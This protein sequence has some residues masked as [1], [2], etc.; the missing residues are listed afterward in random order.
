MH[1]WLKEIENMELDT[2][3]SK[4]KTNVITQ[5]KNKT[6]NKNFSYIE[7]LSAFE[8][9]GR[10][11]SDGREIDLQISNRAILKKICEH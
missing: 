6:Q 5:R 4:T 7:T 1:I 11:I 2:N 3:I 10:I 8:Y 9:L